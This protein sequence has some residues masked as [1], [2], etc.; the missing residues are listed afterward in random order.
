MNYVDQKYNK[1]IIIYL[2]LPFKEKYGI[3]ISE[4]ILH[5]N[6]IKVTEY[7]ESIKNAIDEMLNKKIVDRSSVQMVRMSIEY[8]IL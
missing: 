7:G 2:Q 6:Y 3:D 5:D 8:F 4:T 1:T